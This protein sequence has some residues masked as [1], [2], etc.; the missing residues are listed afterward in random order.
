MS[1]TRTWLVAVVGV[2]V[3][4]VGHWAID[5]GLFSQDL[6]ARSEAPVEKRASV[7]RGIARS[8]SARAS[9]TSAMESLAAALRQPTGAQGGARVMEIAAN[10]PVGEIGA[11]LAS[12]DLVPPGTLRREF[13]RSILARWAQAEPAAAL[14]WVRAQPTGVGRNDGWL[15]VL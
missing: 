9:T 8:G 12:L 1:A 3:G 13:V 6:R 11:I 4:A 5:R 2:A 10:V 15:A 14:A 7:S